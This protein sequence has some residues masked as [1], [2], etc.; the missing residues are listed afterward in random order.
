MGRLASSDGKTCLA[1][2]KVIDQSQNQLEVIESHILRAVAGQRYIK[3]RED[4][5]EER[6]LWIDKQVDRDAG[7][8]G[9]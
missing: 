1:V 2:R 5:R 7:L 3:V 4:Q 6:Y 9:C 8:F